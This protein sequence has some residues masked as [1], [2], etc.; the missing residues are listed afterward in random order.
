MTFRSVFEILQSSH[1]SQKVEIAV[2]LTIRKVEGRDEI[3]RFKALEGEYHYM[4]E[5]HSG[6]D[7]MRLVIE[8]G[9]EWMALMVWGSACYHLKARDE[10]VGW[11]ASLRVERLKLVVSNRRFT[12]LKRPGERKNLASQ[13][14][15]LAT[16]ELP[17]LWI[18]EFGYRPLLAETFC[19]IERAAGTCYKA[20]NWTPLGVT[21]G[22]T[23]TNRQECDF[24]VPND[25]P[26]TLWVRPLDRDALRLLNSRELPEDCRRGAMGDADGVMPLNVGARESLYEA[27]R[28]VKDHRDRNRSFPIGGIL[29]IVVMAMMSGANSVKA[30]SRFAKRLTM[31]QR[32]E[33]CMPHA[34]SAAGV[35]A[36]HEY[37]VPG[38]VTLY[39]FLKGLD[40][41]DFG[42]KLSAWMA[43]EDGTL[44]RQ[45]ALDGKFVKDVMGVVSV[46]NAETG[47]PVAV[48]VASNKEGEGDKC[49]LAVGRRLLR[50]SDL[51]NALVSSDALHCQQETARA[52][53]CANGENLMQI[54][55]NQPGLLRNAKAVVSARHPVDSKK[56]ESAGTDVSRLG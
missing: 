6:G 18:R 9:G 53:A 47:A 43:A 28:H 16:R 41:D 14:L 38:Y 2:A 55:A 17:G 35:V 26:K 46:V 22:F 37:R 20:A 25:R 10:Y 31:A 36:K 12:I 50:E 21:K 3:K 24:Y 40:L 8:E 54:K 45:L 39:D 13:C 7:T 19:D 52:V 27:L 44:P 34:K 51:T 30:I 5:T 15:G 56:N 42:R 48:A 49:E 29:S 1:K 11:P 23:R 33:L 32:R 4:G